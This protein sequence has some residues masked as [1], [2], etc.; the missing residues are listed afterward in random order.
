MQNLEF[1]S[2][3]DKIA[4][5]LLET[6][7]LCRLYNTKSKTLQSCA[8]KIKFEIILRENSKL[9][10]VSGS[11]KVSII[12]ELKHTKLRTFVVTDNPRKHWILRNIIETTIS[13][14]MKI[15]PEVKDWLT[16]KRSLLSTVEGKEIY[17]KSYISERQLPNQI[18]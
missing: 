8:Y 1:F 3:N 7:W 9:G 5:R 4:N 6:L 18:Y 17:T 13:L 16:S 2:W 14:P 12:I 11:F 10:S 15:N